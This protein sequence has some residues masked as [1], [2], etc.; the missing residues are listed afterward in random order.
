VSSSFILKKV[1]HLLSSPWSGWSGKLGEGEKGEKGPGR[2]WEGEQCGRLGGLKGIVG[3]GRKCGVWVT[4][5]GELVWRKSEF[6]V[7]TF[8]IVEF[9]EYI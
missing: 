5:W 1:S 4:L 6:K 2:E 3:H 7:K 8:G 9:Q